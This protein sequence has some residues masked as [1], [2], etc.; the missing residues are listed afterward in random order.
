MARRLCWL[1]R[2]LHQR[3]SLESLSTETVA[4]LAARAGVSV[5]TIYL[6]VAAIRSAGW[7]VPP[8]TRAPLLPLGTVR[9]SMSDTVSL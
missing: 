5:R 8:L 7:P 1:L 6:D 9:A 3:P 2:W 4:Y